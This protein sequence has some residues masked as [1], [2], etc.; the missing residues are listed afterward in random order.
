MFAIKDIETQEWFT[1]NNA[2]FEFDT[3][4]ELSS[5]FL[6]NNEESAKQDVEAYADLYKL[7]VVPITLTWVE[8]E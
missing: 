8:H 2:D 6:Y 3:A 7:E 4:K 1:T 5:R